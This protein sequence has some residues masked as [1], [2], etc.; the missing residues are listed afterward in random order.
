MLLPETLSWYRD[1]AKWILSLSL[2]ALGAFVGLAGFSEKISNAGPWPKAVFVLGCL[3]VLGAVI[4]GVYFNLFIAQFGNVLEREEAL[5]NPSPEESRAIEIE[6]DQAETGY[7]WAYRVLLSC[8]VLSFV[9]FTI[10]GFWLLFTHPEKAD[11]PIAWFAIPTKSS[12][13][14]QEHKAK[15]QGVDFS[16]WEQ[17]LTSIAASLEK[18]KD[19]LPQ[20]SAGVRNPSQP[21]T[22]IQTGS[23][24]CNCPDGKK[25]AKL[26]KDH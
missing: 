19:A 23:S 22:V 11:T 2:G 8:F 10:I 24:G 7:Y 17:K 1:T 20:P 12:M 3:I 4:A 25:C 9:A 21:I 18:I 6:R 5:D 13:A 14:A 26:C 15:M 16:A